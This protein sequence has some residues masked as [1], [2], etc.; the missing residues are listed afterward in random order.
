MPV[1]LTDA[2]IARLVGQRKPVP[3]DWR[4]RLKRKAKGG[5]E[6]AQTD[7]T[8]VDGDEFRVIVR[9]SLFN[10]LAFSV[11]LAWKVPGSNALFRLRRYNGRAHEHS[12]PI[13]GQQFFAA[14][15]HIATERYQ[16]LGEREDFFAEPTGRFAELDGALGCMAADCGFE[17]APTSQLALFD[18]ETADAQR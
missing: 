3:A 14:H 15:I 11:I 9:Q 1:R 10:P 6:E 18:K 8:G 13:E 2:D 7:L 4:A 17:T 16:A 12:N 5:H